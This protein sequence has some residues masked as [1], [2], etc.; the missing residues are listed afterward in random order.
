VDFHDWDK[1]AAVVAD[2]RKLR[3]Q[4]HDVESRPGALAVTICGTYQDEAIVAPARRVVLNALRDKE[5]DL[6]G[7]LMVM[8]LYRTRDGLEPRALVPD[9]DGGPP[10]V[11]EPA[12]VKPAPVA[13]GPSAPRLNT[14]NGRPVRDV[15][16]HDLHNMD[17]RIPP[18][19]GVKL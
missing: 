7:D 2:L 4:I 12:P 9:P 16:P 8:G 1:A 18:G 17:S 6:E 13:T 10:G 19:I 5:A 3:A 14:I 15:E 11:P